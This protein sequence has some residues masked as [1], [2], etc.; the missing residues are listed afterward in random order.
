MQLVLDDAQI[1]EWYDE[2]VEDVAW[3]RDHDDL[4][5]DHPDVGYR[6]GVPDSYES[7]RADVLKGVLD[8]VICAHPGYRLERVPAS[9]ASVPEAVTPTEGMR[10]FG[11]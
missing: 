11:A 10:P 5:P 6:T 3:Y 7:Y 4:K 1:R 9:R 8:D 2:Y